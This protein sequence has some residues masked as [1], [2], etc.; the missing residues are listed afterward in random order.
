[1]RCKFVNDGLRF[2]GLKIILQRILS[3]R[4]KTLPL[5]CC[6]CIIKIRG[7]KWIRWMTWGEKKREKEENILAE[8]WWTNK[9]QQSHQKESLWN[10]WK[11]QQGASSKLMNHELSSIFF[12]KAITRRNLRFMRNSTS[13]I[14]VILSKVTPNSQSREFQNILNSLTIPLQWQKKKR[15]PR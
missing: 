10:H 11:F 7:G 15:C 8:I 5:F 12:G 3:E 2:V 4:G 9:D 13:R 14:F 1:M 6:C